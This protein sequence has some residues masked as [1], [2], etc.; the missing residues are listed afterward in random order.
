MFSA[1]ITMLQAMFVRLILVHFFPAV[2]LAGIDLTWL[3]ETWQ[4]EIV[5]TV[6][7][8]QSHP[9]QPPLWSYSLA[10]HQCLLL[11][12]NIFS[13][14][15]QWMISSLSPAW[16]MCVD[17]W[18]TSTRLA[19]VDVVGSQVEVVEVV[20]H[21]ITMPSRVQHAMI[22]SL[23]FSPPRGSQQTPECPSSASYLQYH[24][25]A[26]KRGETATTDLFRRTITK[27]SPERI[28]TT[29]LFCLEN[30]TTWIILHHSAKKVFLRYS[31]I[32]FVWILHL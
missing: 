30:F 1:L 26:A 28:F 3:T 27:C 22:T 25:V 20:Y 11:R 17:M 5:I 2:R 8:I 7:F 23:H 31:V 15:T 12:T 18:S 24:F 9:A 19:L 21:Y 6:I 10:C 29:G 13:Q 16:I 32:R 4:K 14:P